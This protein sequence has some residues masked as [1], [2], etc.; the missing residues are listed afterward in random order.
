MPVFQGELT[1]FCLSWRPNDLF[2]RDELELQRALL[3]KTGASGDRCLWRCAYIE[4][5]EVYLQVQCRRIGSRHQPWMPS[6]TG[7]YCNM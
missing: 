4:E 5:F 3:P 7:G 6:Y 2:Q 1:K